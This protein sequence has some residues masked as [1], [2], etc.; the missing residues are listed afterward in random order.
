MYESRRITFDSGLNHGGE[1]HGREGREGGK[2]EEPGDAQTHR[3]GA[4]HSPCAL[5]SRTEH[6][7]RGARGVER[8]AGEWLHHGLEA[9]P[10]HDGQGPRRARRH[11]ARP[12]LL[13][14]T[15]RAADA[16]P[17]A[18]RPGRP[19][20]RRLVGQARAAGPFRTPRHRSGASRHS[21]AAR[22]AGTGE[23]EMTLALPTGPL[24]QAMGWA[25]NERS[26]GK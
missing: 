5:E 11:P 23:P 24:V 6:G 16:A 18:R 7:S 1:A 25:L 3:W 15:G 4:G 26:R 13:V 8:L 14:A 10:D 12:R 21:R 22:G 17:A 20:V 19:R 2:T 9:A